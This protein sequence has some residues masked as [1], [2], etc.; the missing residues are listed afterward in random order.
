MEKAERVVPN[1]QATI[2]CVS[3]DVRQQG[4]QVDLAPPVSSAMQAPL[5]PSY[6][7]AR[8]AATR[9]VTAG[10]PLR[11]LAH[12]LRAPLCAPGGVFRARKPT[13]ARTCSSAQPP[14][15]KDATAPSREGT[16]NCAGST[17]RESARA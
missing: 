6:D 2:A 9:T 10:A 4:R 1:M 17:V 8:V 14:T 7:L 13:H 15:S 16:I 5:M 11:D 3:G 12:H